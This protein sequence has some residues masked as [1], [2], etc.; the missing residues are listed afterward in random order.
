MLPA[1][2]CAGLPLDTASSNL[3]NSLYIEAALGARTVGTA[4]GLKKQVSLVNPEIDYG[5]GASR[6][7]MRKIV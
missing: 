4:P 1:R 7:G 5:A 6:R 2:G 3:K